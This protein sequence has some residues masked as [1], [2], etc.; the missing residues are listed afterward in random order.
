MVIAHVADCAE[1]RAVLAGLAREP[2]ASAVTQHTPAWWMRARVWM[3]IAASVVLAVGAGWL[4]QNRGDRGSG[5]T[6]STPDQPAVTSPTATT[7]APSVSE[8]RSAPEPQTPPADL[9]STRR[10][11]ERTVDGKRFRL[12][13]GAWIDETYDPF[14]LLPA[15]DVRT[16]DERDELLARVPALRP[17]AALGPTVTVVR[18]GTVYRF[19]VPR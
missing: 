1:C 11:G 15:V 12:E 17:F 19:D 2:V 13:A 3:P 8:P 5:Q 16:A 10:G 14:S 7:P 6:P 4:A 9:G 18:G